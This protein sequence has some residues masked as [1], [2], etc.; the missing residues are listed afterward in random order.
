[1]AEKKKQQDESAKDDLSGATGQEAQQQGREYP[2]RHITMK[3]C[4]GTPPLPGWIRVG[5][6][7]DGNNCGGDPT[8]PYDYNIWIL[9]NYA[10]NT[11]YPVGRVI[12]VCA[13]SPTPQGWVD[14]NYYWTY[15]GCGHPS[16]PSFKNMK[17]IKRVQ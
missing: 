2:S 15:T 10:D 6:E 3:V 5:D 8:N 4:R 9:E 13:D 17:D 14:V 16:S 7:H 1:M 11:I 12:S